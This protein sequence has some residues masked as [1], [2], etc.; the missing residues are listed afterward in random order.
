MLCARMYAVP[1]ISGDWSPAPHLMG[2]ADTWKCAPPHTCYRTKFDRHR[3]RSNRVGVKNLRDARS[4]GT[5]EIRDPPEKWPLAFLRI[6]QGHRTDRDRS[7]TCDLNIFVYVVFSLIRLTAVN[8]CVLTM[9]GQIRW[10]WLSGSPPYIF[11]MWLIIC[12]ISLW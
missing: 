12:R 7:A 5:S 1:K 6:I 2:V 3:S 8:I 10:L 9:D 4:I 11:A